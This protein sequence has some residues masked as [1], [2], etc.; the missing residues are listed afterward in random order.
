MLFLECLNYILRNIM[1]FF[2][3]KDLNSCIQSRR[4]KYPK[5]DKPKCV[6][7]FDVFKLK[8]AISSPLL[9][10]R[11]KGYSTIDQIVQLKNQML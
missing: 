7:T 2:L 5:L 4:S 11:N 9:S 1:F 10:H 6:Q 3:L 8:C